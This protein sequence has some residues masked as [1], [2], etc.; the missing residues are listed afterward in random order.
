MKSCQL[1][2]VWIMLY[3][4]TYTAVGGRGQTGAM[5]LFSTHWRRSYQT[6]SDVIRIVFSLQMSSSLGGLGRPPAVRQKLART[7]WGRGLINANYSCRRI[8]GTSLL[9]L[10]GVSLVLWRGGRQKTSVATPFYCP[11]SPNS[12][13][14]EFLIYSFYTFKNFC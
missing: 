10:F 7:P 4:M 13:T 11:L 12:Q 9:T 6:R 1:N 2:C 8:F 3:T 14:S 5:M